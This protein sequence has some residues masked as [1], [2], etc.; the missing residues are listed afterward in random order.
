MREAPGRVAMVPNGRK[1]PALGWVVVGRFG[2]S[3]RPGARGLSARAFRSGWH[4]VR[5]DPATLAAT[6]ALLAAVALTAAWAPAQETVCI[7]P[8]ETLKSE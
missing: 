7:D 8:L 1:P 2:T 6:A 3:S 4:T 5:A